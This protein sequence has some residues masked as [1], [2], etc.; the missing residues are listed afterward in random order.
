MA[1]I[2]VLNIGYPRYFIVTMACC[3]E[4]FGMKLVGDLFL[5]AHMRRPPCDHVV[6]V[7]LRLVLCPAAFIIISVC[8]LTVKVRMEAER[9]GF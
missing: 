1:D 4:I 2:L 3:Q 9:K 6:E 7:F 8:K 5:L